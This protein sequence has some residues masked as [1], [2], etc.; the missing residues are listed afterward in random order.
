[1]LLAFP[2][3]KKFEM[4]KERAENERLLAAILKFDPSI[5]SEDDYWYCRKNGVISWKLAGSRLEQMQERWKEWC[6]MPID[7]L[8]SLEPLMHMEAF[9]LTPSLILDYYVR[10]RESQISLETLGAS[11]D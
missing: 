1:L 10:W 3:E 2:K 5:G 6:S 8:E 7:E 11:N 9:N 4:T